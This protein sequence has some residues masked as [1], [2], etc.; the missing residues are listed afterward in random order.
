MTGTICNLSEIED[1]D[2]K[3][4]FIPITESWKVKKLLEFH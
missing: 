4:Y 2:T 3:F 1:I